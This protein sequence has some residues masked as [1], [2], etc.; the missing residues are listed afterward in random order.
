[1]PLNSHAAPYTA[2][3]MQGQW[4]LHATYNNTM[5]IQTHAEAKTGHLN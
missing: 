3:C 1:M 5:A 4:V 2:F